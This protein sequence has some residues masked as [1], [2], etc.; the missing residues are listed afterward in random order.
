MSGDVRHSTTRGHPCANGAWGKPLPL[1]GAFGP[2]IFHAL[3]KL[4]HCAIQSDPLQSLFLSASHVGSLSRIV[5]HENTDI[6]SPPNPK[7][8]RGAWT[9]V[10]DIPRGPLRT[11]TKK[12]QDGL[13]FVPA[14]IPQPMANAR[15]PF[16][17]RVHPSP[18]FP[19][20]RRARPV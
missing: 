3:H 14:G 17:G 10:C 8:N 9:P 13:G 19:V 5:T 15:M 1:S 6:T 2:N 12:P 11:V 4:R 18:T 7:T 16:G 20:S